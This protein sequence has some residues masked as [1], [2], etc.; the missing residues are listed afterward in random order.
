MAE[1]PCVGRGARKERTTEPV[2]ARLDTYDKIS[3][4]LTFG[5]NEDAALTSM[6][7]LRMPV[8]AR[9]CPYY[10]PGTLFSS[11]VDA[12]SRRVGAHSAANL[13]LAE[14]NVE[15]AMDGTVAAAPVRAG[16][17]KA[18]TDT[19]CRGRR[20][21]AAKRRSR[22]MERFLSESRNASIGTTPSVSGKH[23]LRVL[24]SLIPDSIDRARD[25]ELPSR[26]ESEDPC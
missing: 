4:T 12:L 3:P 22:W 25:S 16:R 26:N 10:V 2:R 7:P 9:G 13:V 8:I 5:L 1:R 18:L 21:G 11:E 23:R 24:S 15:S 19:R 17:R 14:R 20:F 6:L